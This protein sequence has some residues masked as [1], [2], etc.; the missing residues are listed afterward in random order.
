MYIYN[1]LL[2]QNDKHI[3]IGLQYANELRAV[4]KKDSI[5]GLNTEQLSNWATYG[6]PRLSI[7][8]Y[9]PRIYFVMYSC[10]LMH[11]CAA[12]TC[13]RQCK[14]SC[15]HTLDHS[16]FIQKW[17]Y[18]LAKYTVPMKSAWQSYGTSCELSLIAYRVAQKSKPLS[19]IIIKSY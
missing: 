18:S 13:L 12:L 3:C 7:I 16:S 4:F 2:K 19:R 15:A 10:S 9:F 5:N 6:W 14:Y 8:M 11:L 17:Q 1:R